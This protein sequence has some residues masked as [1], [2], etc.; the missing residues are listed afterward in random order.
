MPVFDR[1]KMF[2]WTFSLVAGSLIMIVFNLIFYGSSIATIILAASTA[3]NTAFLAT[4]Y[5]NESIDALK[6]I[7]C[8]GD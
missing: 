3:I 8:R 4:T 7:F 1:D 2:A 5:K 6:R